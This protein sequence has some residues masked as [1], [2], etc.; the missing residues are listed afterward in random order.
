[1]LCICY[2]L[3]PEVISWGDVIYNIINIELHGASRADMKTRGVN[4]LKGVIKDVELNTIKT[5]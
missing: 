3:S 2:H 5:K 4:K 1:M